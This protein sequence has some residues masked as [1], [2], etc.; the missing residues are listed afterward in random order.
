MFD[1]DNISPSSPLVSIVV[2]MYKVED[3]LPQ[4]LDSILA[5]MYSNLEVVCVDDGSPDASG[6]IAEEYAQKDGRIRVVHQQN[7]GLPAARNTGLELITG[8]YVC[9]FRRL[10]GS[11]FCGIYAAYNYITAGRNGHFQELFYYGRPRAGEV[12]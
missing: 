9:R 5:Q 3:Y 8:D 6:R 2:P 7:K 1:M 10:S 12:R 11:R 4:C